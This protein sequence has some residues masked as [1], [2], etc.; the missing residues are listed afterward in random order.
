MFILYGLHS[1]IVLF[2]QN[3]QEKGLEKPD[4]NI[5]K[6]HKQYKNTIHVYIYISLK[7]QCYPSSPKN[8]TLLPEEIVGNE[9]TSVLSPAT[10]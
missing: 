5:R 9:S 1:E 3:S 2:R 6:E 7:K 10:P 8:C 4:K